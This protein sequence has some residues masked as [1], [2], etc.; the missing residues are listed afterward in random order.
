MVSGTAA[1]STAAGDAVNSAGAYVGSLL[2]RVARHA[3][4]QPTSPAVR[5]DR[6]RAFSYPGLWEA[7]GEIADL[8]RACGAERGQVALM[9]LPNRAEYQAVFVGALRAGLVP[10]TVPTTTSRRALTQMMD[11]VGARVVITN[12]TPPASESLR[13]VRDAAASS[14]WLCDVVSVS[15]AGQ[16]VAHGTHPGSVAQPAD[17]AL[18]HVMFTSSTTGEPKAVMHTEATLEALN[19]GFAERF[20][21][22]ASTSIFMPSPLGHSVGGI[23]GIRLALYLG[24][25][26]V[27]QDT[28]DPRGALALVEET[29]AEFTAAATPFLRDLVDADAPSTGPKLASLRTF[30]CGGAQVPPRLLARC[31]TEFPNTFVTVLWGMT[32][33]GVTTCVPGD[34]PERLEETAGRGLPGLELRILGPDGEVLPAGTEG[35][36]AMRGPGVFVGYLAQDDLYRQLMTPDGFFRTGDLAVLDDHGYV[37]ITGR[38]KDLIIRGA[39]NISPVPTE[40][41]LAAHPEITDVAVVGAPDDRLGERI[42]AVV[43]SRRELSLDEILAW[44]ADQG[45]DKRQWPERLVNVPTFPRTAAGKIRKAQLRTELFQD[46]PQEPA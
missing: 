6:G 44:C 9:V 13:T 19:A 43:T 35:E 45:L 46:Y 38:A 3:A 42:C 30:L 39:V 36:L 41:V 29:G 16:V 32:E 34:G 14:R 22:D 20:E 1:S 33:G 11:R 25:E 27:L 28:W 31:R 40:N 7:A 18:A 37:R 5:D 24:A 17:S 8:F 15:D 12:A 2:A 23:H 26:L 4:T 21:L 10:A